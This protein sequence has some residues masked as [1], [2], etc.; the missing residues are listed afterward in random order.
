MQRSASLFMVYMIVMASSDIQ[1]I[2]FR[3]DKQTYAVDILESREIIRKQK[4]HEYPKLPEFI[5]GVINL[6]GKIIPVIDLKKRLKGSHMTILPSSRLIIVRLKK[7]RKLLFGLLVDQVKQVIRCSQQDL[8][9][10]PEALND[11]D[12]AFIKG[13]LS[14]KE[15]L[16]ILLDLN[17]LF[18][19]PE[20]SYIMNT[21]IKKV[22][23]DE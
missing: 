2:S 10:P 8:F 6:R 20:K 9:A 7:Q 3:L 22:I 16:I 14:Y 5:E 18:T 13:L 4:I 15:D 1:L 19:Q 12:H 17:K 21:N 11:I 23:A